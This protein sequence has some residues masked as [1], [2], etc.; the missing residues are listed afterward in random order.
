[1]WDQISENSTPQCHSA[2][3]REILSHQKI[4]RQINYLVKRY[5]HEILGLQNTM[6]QNFSKCEDKVKK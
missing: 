4:F 2:E 5:F 3:K 1:M 6:L